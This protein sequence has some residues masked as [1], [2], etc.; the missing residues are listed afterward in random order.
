[1]L[2]W[3]LN[4]SDSQTSTVGLLVVV[5]VMLLSRTAVIEKKPPRL[6]PL[7]ASSHWRLRRSTLSSV[8][9]TSFLG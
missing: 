8:C 9:E 2:L 7:V 6:V 4:M 5:G 3:L 1:M